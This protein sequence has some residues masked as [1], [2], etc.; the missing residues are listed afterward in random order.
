[1]RWP[2]GLETG[3]TATRFNARED[4]AAESK[5]MPVVDDSVVKAGRQSARSPALFRFPASRC[6][7]NRDAP[8]ADSSHCVAGS[9]QEIAVRGDCGLHNAG[10]GRPLVLPQQLPVCSATLVA[11]VALISR[12][13]P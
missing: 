6:M 4:A 9:D 5:C 13:A 10:I 7:G 1:M 12:M 11:P 3:E 2:S 8:H